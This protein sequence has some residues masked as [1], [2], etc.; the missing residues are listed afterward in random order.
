[1]IYDKSGH[2]L[3]SVYSKIGSAINSAYDVT[4][5]LVFH[6]GSSDVDYTSYS[7]S[8][9][10][11]ASGVFFSTQ[12]LDIYDS[13]VFWVTGGNG[14]VEENCYVWNLSD[15]SPAISE[16]PFTVYSGHGNNICIDFPKL[17]ASTAYSPNKVYVNTLSAVTGGYEATLS[18]TLFLTDGSVDLDV[19]LDEND[20]TIL[21]S[22]GHQVDHDTTRP[23]NISKWDLTNL[24]ENADGT[25]T[26]A[27]LQTVQTPQPEC[28]YFQGFKMHDGI[29]W[30][31]SGYTG[32]TYEAYVYG[33][34]PNTGE[35]LYTIDTGLTSEPEG[36]AWVA[37]S[38]S[39]GGYALYIGF[40]GMNL[41][42]C[43]FT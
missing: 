6:G 4:G 43:I 2:S 34:N 7:I 42:K 27:L 35:L 11:T 25:F 13:K 41:Y 24:T 15:G 14:T 21:W 33:V 10:W 30:Y 36:V 18:K 28:Y 3:S 31:A 38:A 39:E 1:M 40:G 29:L 12:G 20:K 26:P 5:D 23:Y 19:A 16:N 32:G 22:L 8:K 17:Y 9:K 37:D